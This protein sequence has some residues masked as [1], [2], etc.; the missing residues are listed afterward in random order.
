M[1]GREALTLFEQRV[2][3]VEA[4]ER[5]EILC[6]GDLVKVWAHAHRLQKDAQAL[7]GKQEAED[8]HLPS[9]HSWT[10]LERSKVRATL[11]YN[12]SQGIK[13]ALV[14]LCAAVLGAMSW[15][16]V[17]WI[18]QSRQLMGQA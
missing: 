5:V 4:K 13:L 11:T 2:K 17:R 16:R 3:V 9:Q 10:Q 8:N 12:T 15:R 18:L 1:S 14:P 7:L 6:K